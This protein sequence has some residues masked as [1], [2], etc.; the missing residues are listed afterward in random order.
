[1]NQ[2]NT[3]TIGIL[4]RH[5]QPVTCAGTTRHHINSLP[6]IVIDELYNRNYDLHDEQYYYIKDKKMDEILKHCI[7]NERKR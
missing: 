3:E 1:M 7:E 5:E 6:Q 2:N 4:K